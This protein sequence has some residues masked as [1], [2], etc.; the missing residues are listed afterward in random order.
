[1]NGNRKQNILRKRENSFF[2]FGFLYDERTIGNKRTIKK[3]KAKII[4]RLFIEC[5][6]NEL[7]TVHKVKFK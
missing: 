2:F 7:L 4:H 6:L 1:M 5:E 3:V